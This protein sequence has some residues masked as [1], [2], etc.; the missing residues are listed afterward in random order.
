MLE[1][2]V[3]CHRKVKGFE[4]SGRKS[5]CSQSMSM[6]AQDFSF[7]SDYACFHRIPHPFIGLLYV[8]SE[9]GKKFAL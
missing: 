5:L 2:E 6:F 7:M 1:F 3:S 8:G 4:L 9:P